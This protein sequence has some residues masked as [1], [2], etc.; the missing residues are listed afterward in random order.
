MRKSRA[1]PATQ[2]VM[3]EDGI[4]KMLTWNSPALTGMFNLPPIT[5]EALQ[6]ESHEPVERKLDRL[7]RLADGSYLHVEHQTSLSGLDA[8]AERMIR[9]RVRTRGFVPV[10]CDLHQVIVFTGAVP[11]D[12]TMVPSALV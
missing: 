10:R 8:L 1:K 3:R 2:V 4:F 9:Y 6:Q 11:G 7:Y 5:G 12:R